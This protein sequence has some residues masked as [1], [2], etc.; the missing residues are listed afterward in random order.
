MGEARGLTSQIFGRVGVKIDWRGRRHCPTNSLPIDVSLDTPADTFPGA[1]G[2]AVPGSSARIVIFL[3]RIRRNAPE[4]LAPRILAHVFA[5]E[6]TH[7]LRGDRRHSDAGL[8]KAH[9][10]QS[11]YHGMARGFLP[12]TAEDVRLI[13]RALTR[14]ALT[15]PALATPVQIAQDKRTSA[16]GA[17]R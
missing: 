6:I 4:A 12:F 17:R 16:E 15:R 8:M 5:H 1:L 3:D 13:E 2:F 9:W 14:P 10:E 7:V 11:D